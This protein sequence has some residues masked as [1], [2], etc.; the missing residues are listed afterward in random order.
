MTEPRSDKRIPAGS[1]EIC[2]LAA[3]IDGDANALNRASDKMTRPALRRLA[4]AARRLADH[5][6]WVAGQ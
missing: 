4:E 3:V 5:C 2:A 6:D 1:P